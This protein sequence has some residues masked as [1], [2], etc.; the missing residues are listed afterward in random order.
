MNI[1][2]QVL[3]WTYVLISLGYLLK[4]GI[5]ESNGDF[6]ILKNSFPK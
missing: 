4:S 2:V 5:A 6:N 1:Y 3:V